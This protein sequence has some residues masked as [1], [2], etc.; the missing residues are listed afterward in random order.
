MSPDT[1]QAHSKLLPSDFRMQ[2]YLRNSKAIRPTAIIYCVR[3][4]KR[5]LNFTKSLKIKPDQ[6]NKETQRAIV[7]HRLPEV[8]NLVNEKINKQLNTDSQ[9]FQD[10]IKALSE[11]PED[12][13][14][15]EEIIRNTL[16]AKKTKHS[17]IPI[18]IDLFK[19][20]ERSVL[21]DSSIGDNTQKNYIHK[22]IKAFKAFSEYR[23]QTGLAPISSVEQ[24]D[25]DLIAEFSEYLGSGKY[26]QPSGAPYAMGTINSIIKYAVSAIKCLPGSVLPKSKA[27]L[28]QAPQLKDKTSDKNEIALN[29][30]EMQLLIKYVPTT[31]SD[32][33]ILDMFI[34]ECTTGQRVSDVGKLVEGLQE[35][36]GIL[37]ISIL[38]DKGSEKIEAPI[39]FEIARDILFKYKN[40]LPKV[41]KDKINKNIKRICEAA[42]VTG[43][44]LQSR[45]YVGSDKP[46]AFKKERFSLIST[47]TGRRTFVSLLA[48][49]GW[50]YEKIAK[51]TGHT[52]IKTVQ[53]YDK[54][55]SMDHEAFKGLSID[56]RLKLIGEEETNA[57]TI[58]SQAKDALDVLLGAGK[59][60][61]LRL[62][63]KGSMDLLSISKV[64]QDKKDHIISENGEDE[65]LK[66]REALQFGHTQ[67]ERDLLGKFF[68]SVMPK[69]HGRPVRIIGFEATQK[70]WHEVEKKESTDLNNENQ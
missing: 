42:G 41:G 70:Y 3:W 60:L 8:Y 67:E 19:E 12:L 53:H 26:K 40:G 57:E 32:R 2:F 9:K 64:L 33:E 49:R 69:W 16:M 1:T 68:C 36:N 27:L 17:S 37:Y 34:L 44:E 30:I 54:S 5:R 52:N 61:G 39:I 7:S 13:I 55:T 47:H 51:C 11:Y 14:T 48:V 20:L 4:G 22:G 66:I 18:S 21:N 28:L 56:Q 15:F 58:T 50:T 46:K 63:P 25:S 35:R 59:L 38:Q 10:I 65:Y 45:H 62:A 23:E 31:S 6:W 24:L 43:E 29:D